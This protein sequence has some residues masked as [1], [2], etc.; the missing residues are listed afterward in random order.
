[1]PLWLGLIGT[2]GRT[3]LSVECKLCCGTVS[4]LSHEGGND[5]DGIPQEPVW[6]WLLGF[7]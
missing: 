3:H 1:M 6:R 4:I 5:V 2:V 7:E